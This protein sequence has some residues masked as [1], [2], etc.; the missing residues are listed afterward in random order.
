MSTQ[1][2]ATRRPGELFSPRT[3][4]AIIAIGTAAFVGMIYLECSAPVT[5]FEIGPAPIQLALGHKALME[6]AAHR[7]AGG[8]QPLPLGREDR[9][10]GLLVL[11]SPMAAKPR[12][13]CRRLATCH[14]LLC[15]E[16]GRQP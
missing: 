5:N 7:R 4:L 10:G 11:A 15:T 2:E 13:R 3:L 16:V 9:Q 8:G 14:G 1:G 12:R 6:T